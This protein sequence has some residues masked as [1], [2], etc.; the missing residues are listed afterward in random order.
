MRF[1]RLIR[2]LNS[3]EGDIDV[4]EQLVQMSRHTYLIGNGGSAA[5]AS[6]IATDF[7]KNAG[8]SASAFNDVSLL[9]C[10]GNDYGYD[11]VFKEALKHSPCQAHDLLIAISSSGRSMNIRNAV[12]WALD[13]D[14]NVLTLSGFDYDNPL[15]QMGDVNL[16]VPASDYGTVEITHMAILHSMVPA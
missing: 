14:L 16:W 12:E 4:A 15:R 1:D 3:V 6:H 9:T 11:N 8:Y 2:G 5:I 10:F 7:A 13:R